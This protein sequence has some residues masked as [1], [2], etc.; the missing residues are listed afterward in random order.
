MKIRELHQYLGQ[1]MNQ[2]TNP[3]LEVMV[4]DGDSSYSNIQYKSVYVMP[5]DD[6]PEIDRLVILPDHWVHDEPTVEARE[7]QAHYD[8]M[9]PPLG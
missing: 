9:N 4:P 5:N 7:A 6:D 3:E 1:M 8:D 2:G